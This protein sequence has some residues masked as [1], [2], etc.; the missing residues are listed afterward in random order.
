MTPYFVLGWL[1]GWLV[2]PPPPLPCWTRRAV[3]AAHAGVAHTFDNGSQ[4]Q[5]LSFGGGGGGSGGGG[6]GG[7]AAAG[8]APGKKRARVEEEEQGGAGQEEGE[9]EG[10]PPSAPGGVAQVLPE[11]TPTDLRLVRAVEHQLAAGASVESLDWAGVA[12]AVD[13]GW[14]GRQCVMRFLG[15]RWKVDTPPPPVVPATMP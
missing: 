14:S 2:A 15:V 6:G 8:G 3:D 10:A 9:G 12:A 4:G 1:I 7:T 11:L 5:G 13:N